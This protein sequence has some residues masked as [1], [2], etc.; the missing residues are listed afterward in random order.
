MAGTCFGFPISS[1]FGSGSRYA[2]DCGFQ[3]D[4]TRPR[5]VRPTHQLHGEDAQKLVSRTH[6]CYRSGMNGDS[7][8]VPQGIFACSV[9]SLYPQNFQAFR[10]TNTPA[11][12]Y[13]ASGHLSARIP[14]KEYRALGHLF[15]VPQGISIPCLGASFYRASGHLFSSNTV[16]WGIKTAV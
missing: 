11:D 12:E 2:L 4:G 14:P 16:P 5:E 15:T 10:G 9:L 3:C 6:V 7:N 8:T 13:R 1:R